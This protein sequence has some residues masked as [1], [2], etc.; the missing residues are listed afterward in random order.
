MALEE[1]LSKIITNLYM[2]TKKQTLQWNSCPGVC[3]AYMCTFENYIYYIDTHVFGV[4]NI[5]MHYD[6]A[7]Y[8]FYEYVAN[9]YLQQTVLADLD[10]VVSTIMFDAE[11]N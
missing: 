4:N 1:T 5:R 10:K 6:D 2:L 9:Q 8:D 11:I 3:N 7:G